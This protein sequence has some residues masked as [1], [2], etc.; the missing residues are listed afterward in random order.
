MPSRY[1]EGLTF[2]G[3]SS[4]PQTAG[5]WPSARPG[6]AGGPPDKVPRMK[7]LPE[8]SAAALRE[9]LRVVARS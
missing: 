5:N 7:W 6:E 4:G 8:C 1:E 3:A 9:A 2:S